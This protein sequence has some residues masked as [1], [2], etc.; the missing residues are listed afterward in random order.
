MPYYVVGQDWPDALYSTN[1][2]WPVANQWHWK[3]KDRDSAFHASA[4]ET[5]RAREVEAQRE[6]RREARRLKKQLFGAIIQVPLRPSM[7]P[8]CA[9]RLA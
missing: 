1:A 8:C 7:G 4:I 3:S 5:K 9:V 2:R 6:A